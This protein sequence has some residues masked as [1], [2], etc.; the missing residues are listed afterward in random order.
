MSLMD[1]LVGRDYTVRRMD[2]PL[3][4]AKRLEALGMTQGTKLALRA[5]KPSALV[6]SLR[7]T[8]FA[9][10]RAIAKHIEVW[11]VRG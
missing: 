7:G 5:K 8:R 1:G 10:G 3:K 2:L 11:G 9:L 6:I 4:T